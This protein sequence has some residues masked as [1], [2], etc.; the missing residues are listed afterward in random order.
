[1]VHMLNTICYVLESKKIYGEN[2]SENHLRKKKK[3]TAFNDTLAL[4]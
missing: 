2:E 4:G 1:M 3:A